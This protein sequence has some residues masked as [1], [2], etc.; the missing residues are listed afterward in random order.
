MNNVVVWLINYMKQYAVRSD[1]VSVS[2]GYLNPGI[3]RVV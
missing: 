1:A 2:P 3:K